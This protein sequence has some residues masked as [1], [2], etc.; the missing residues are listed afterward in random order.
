MKSLSVLDRI[1]QK[2]LINFI[3]V[4]LKSENCLNI[5]IIIDKLFKNVSFAVLSN[6]EIEIIIQSFIKNV[7]SLYGAPSVIVSD[8]GSQFI[9]EFW[10]KF[11]ETLNIQCQLSTAFHPQTDE[12]TERI[13]SV[14]EAMLRAFSNWDQTNWKPLLPMIQLVIKNHVAF[15]TEVFLFFLLYN[16]ELDTIQIEPNSSI[17]KSPNVRPPKSWADA[18]MSKMKNAMKF[19]QAA[20]INVQ[21]EQKRQVNCHC[22]ESPQLCVSDKVWLIIEKQYNTGRPSQKL[23][24]KNQKY[25][26]MEV[27]S[28]HTVCLSI[29][30][31]HPIL[32]IDWLCLAADDVLPNQPQLDDQPAP[33]HMD[34]EE[35]WYMDEIIAKEFC[36]HN[37]D[38]IKWL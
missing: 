1:W 21:Q 24:Y 20:I 12:V 32:H 33:I 28:P 13:N 11:C 8:W 26:V 30:G 29:E 35:E 37:C 5:I 25:T 22:W 38:V 23:D 2:I 17:R 16:Y 9:S 3:V 7:F 36:H 15:L 14:I 18:V 19:D 27:I 4:L 6:L 31:V 34:G 10:A